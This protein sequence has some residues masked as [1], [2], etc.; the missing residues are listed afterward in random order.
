M[1]LNKAEDV[2]WTMEPARLVPEETANGRQMNAEVKY[3]LRSSFIETLELENFP[4]DGPGLGGGVRGCVGASE[5]ASIFSITLN[6]CLMVWLYLHGLMPLN[7]HLGRFRPG[8]CKT[9][10]S[11][12]MAQRTLPLSTCGSTTMRQSEM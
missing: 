1:A 4:F 11:S 10:T 6:L 5:T 12:C 3:L 9:S 2:T 8:Q 7:N